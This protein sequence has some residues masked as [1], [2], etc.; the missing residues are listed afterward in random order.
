[1]S[2]YRLG[3]S[4]KYENTV[5]ACSNSPDGS[6]V[7]WRHIWRT[8]VPP[9]VRH[10]AWKVTGQCKICGVEEESEY[11]TLVICP[12]AK[13]LRFAMREIWP[14]P[15]EQQFQYGG[16]D[17]LLWLLEQ[18]TEIQRELVLLMFWR[19][20]YDR[21]QQMHEFVCPSIEGSRRFLDAYHLSVSSVNDTI[22]LH[23]P[24]GKQLK[25]PD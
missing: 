2:A 6:R 14:L 19:I 24:K 20:W 5:G 18:C 21:N 16:P 22:T 13:F 10:F 4:L 25:R 9:K 23:D 3:F 12:H 11:H 8:K 17:W 1:R 15:D 7:L